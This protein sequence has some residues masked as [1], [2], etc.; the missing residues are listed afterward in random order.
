MTDL[1]EGVYM[2]LVHRFIE[3]EQPL[4]LDIKQACKEAGVRSYKTGAQVLSEYF[5]KASDCPVDNL[6]ITCGYVEKNYQDKLIN[7]SRV[8]KKNK[9]CGKLGG[10]AKAKNASLSIENNE[11]QENEENENPS[12]RY[13]FA[14]R[15]PSH[16]TNST[17]STNFTNFTNNNLP[18]PLTN[19]IE[20][21]GRGE[22][23]IEFSG[24]SFQDFITSYP[25]Q[26]DQRKMNKAANLWK[27]GGFEQ[28]AGKIKKSI[29]DRIAFSDWREKIGTDQSKYI[30]D[31]ATFLQEKLFLQKF[32]KVAEKKTQKQIDEEETERLSKEKGYE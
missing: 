2:R 29:A 31:P 6:W 13:V 19:K 32:E 30:P 9:A 7:Y 5:I 23:Y 27:R 12:E 8:I 21:G 10:I 15:N 26:V 25:K 18:N 28:H 4:P 22:D 3:T 17:N 20:E 1:E 24:F 14:R 11:L 16:S